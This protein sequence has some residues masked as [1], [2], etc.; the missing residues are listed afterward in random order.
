MV[1]NLCIDVLSGEIAHSENIFGYFQYKSFFKENIKEFYLLCKDINV[2][3]AA[4]NTGI[5]V[6]YRM[7]DSDWAKN[8][9]H[10]YDK[11]KEMIKDRVESI[12]VVTDSPK[13]A[14]KFFQD[15]INVQLVSSNNA[16]EDFKIMINSSELYC[17][18]STFSWWAAHSTSK[19]SLVIMPKFFEE[20]LG[21]YI[22]KN[23]LKI[24]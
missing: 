6:H 4:S 17:A 15:C 21:I 13:C 16:I 2:M 18:P 10:Y 8:S 1:L 23:R 19:N 5:V 12:L 9:S 14:S 3:Y 7:G 11:V 22:E 24:V 20:K